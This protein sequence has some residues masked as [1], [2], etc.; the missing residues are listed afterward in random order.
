MYKTYNGWSNYETWCV[1]LHLT[2]DEYGNEALQDILRIEKNNYV[3]GRSIR[4]F[5][6]SNYCETEN[7]GLFVADAV[8]AFLGA[9]QWGEIANSNREDEDNEEENEEV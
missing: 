1:N 8:N 2:N 7:C 6:E 5:F 4:E 3:A 9:V